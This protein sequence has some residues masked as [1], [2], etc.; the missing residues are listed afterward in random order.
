MSARDLEHSVL[1]DVDF[2]DLGDDVC[3]GPLAGY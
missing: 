3:G 1:S 2:G